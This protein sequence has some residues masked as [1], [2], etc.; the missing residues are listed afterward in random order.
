MTAGST[1]TPI[2]TTTISSDVSTITFSSI[3]GTYTDLILQ[4]AINLSTSGGQIRFYFNGST[5]TNYSSTNLRGTGSAAQSGRTS[6]DGTIIVSYTDPSSMNSFSLNVMNYA[7]T[8]TYKTTLARNG[9]QNY[10]VEAGVGLWRSTSAITSITLT[11]GD[12]KFSTG[13]TLTLYGIAAA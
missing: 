5:A 6:N 8:T 2:A 11:C 1:Y 3:V 12:G 7:N 9:N 10:A 4:G 13:T